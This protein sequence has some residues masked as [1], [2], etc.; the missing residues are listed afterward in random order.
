MAYQHER[1]YFIAHMAADGLPLYVAQRL[2]RYASTLDR[3]AVAQCNG[4]WPADNGERS[5]IEYCPVCEAGF[6]RSVFR[7]STVRKAADFS[8]H[9]RKTARGALLVC[10]DCRTE[11]LVRAALEPFPAFTPIFGGDP[12]GYVLKLNTPSRAQREDPQTGAISGEAVGV[13]TRGR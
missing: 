13:P 9:H 12:R 11:E 7:A 2:L 3:L 5:G 4:D 8:A 10:P 6:V 1:D